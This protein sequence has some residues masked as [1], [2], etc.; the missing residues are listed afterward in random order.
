MKGFEDSRTNS[1][2]P[3][4]NVEILPE[5]IQKKID[6]IKKD[7]GDVKKNIYVMNEESSTKEGAYGL[8]IKNPEDKGVGMLLIGAIGT[9]VTGIIIYG[10]VVLIKRMTTHPNQDKP[11][12][13][14]RQ[15][16]KEVEGENAPQESQMS[17]MSSNA[18]LHSQ[19][20]ANKDAAISRMMTSDFKGV[21]D[22]TH[23]LKADY[24]GSS[25]DLDSG[26]KLNEETVLP[27]I[28]PMME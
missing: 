10:I 19:Y 27:S 4:A 6:Q 3:F 8:N 22:T 20:D 16:R 9:I 21:Y 1:E 17:V 14:K 15:V 28:I 11:V 26:L 7:G 18:D 25:E 2:D 5:D 13:S 12:R 23:K 24:G